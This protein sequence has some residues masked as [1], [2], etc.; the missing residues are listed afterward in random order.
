MYLR[1][2]EILFHALQVLNGARWLIKSTDHAIA[3]KPR[4]RYLFQT[5]AREI[6]RKRQN[7]NAF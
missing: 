4:L 1:K 7:K 6:K 3:R 2:E 5:T